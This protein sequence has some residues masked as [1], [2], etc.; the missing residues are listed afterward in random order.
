MITIYAWMPPVL[1]IIGLLGFAFSWN[2]G[3]L[4]NGTNREKAVVI[5]TCLAALIVGLFL[6]LS[7]VFV[8]I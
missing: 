8:L 5:F 4:I 3:L 7:P 2:I 6:L 1:I